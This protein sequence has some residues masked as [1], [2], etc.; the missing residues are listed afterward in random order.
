M[1]VAGWEIALA[2][3]DSPSELRGEID[4]LRTA[5]STAELGLR[6]AH[7]EIRNELQLLSS[8][9]GLQVR[10]VDDP[11]ARRELVRCYKRVA[12]VGLVHQLG[13]DDSGTIAADTCV[14]NLGK[15]LQASAETYHPDTRFELRL[16]LS[17]LRWRPGLAARA[18]LI[19]DELIDNALRHA[20]PRASR[21]EIEI[22]LEQDDGRCRL[23]VRDWGPGL[24]PNFNVGASTT[25]GLAMASAV[26]EQLRGQLHL[27][28]APGG[29][30]LATLWL[31]LWDDGSQ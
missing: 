24:P 27:Q 11:R 1:G 2:G 8:L 4:R 28:S 17:P 19:I 5:L 9:L 12:V 14:G 31:P 22:A 13:A 16:S 21:R 7:H 6:R 20:L 3:G 29:G 10:R 30:T 18:A 23:S 26:A 25:L 15:F